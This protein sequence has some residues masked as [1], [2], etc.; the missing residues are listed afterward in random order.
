MAGA[1]H[2]TVK[3]SLVK[4]GWDRRVGGVRLWH[5]HNLVPVTV[6]LC[7]CRAGDAGDMTRMGTE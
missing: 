3:Q 2:L 5:K 6:L 7:L 4:L 1:V